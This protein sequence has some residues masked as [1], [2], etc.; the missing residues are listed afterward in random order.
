MECAHLHLRSLADER[1]SEEKARLILVVRA[2]AE[3]NVVCRGC[4][5]RR[6][7]R[8]VME[9]KERGLT[10]PACATDEPAASL[11]ALPY[12]TPDSRRYVTSRWST[13]ARARLR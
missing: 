12:C 8:D 7:R 1:V 4:A 3:L 11:I 5:S 2:A 9:L 6:I 10:A 13:L